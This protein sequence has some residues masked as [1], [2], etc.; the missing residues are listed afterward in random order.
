MSGASFHLF[1][2]TEGV[3]YD[4]ERESILTSTPIASGPVAKGEPTI[5]NKDGLVSIVYNDTTKSWD[6]A[7]DV[8]VHLKDDPNS[9]KKKGL[10]KFYCPF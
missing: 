4:F 8:M 9:M 2:F 1:D 5:Y 10:R 7:L 6:C 3:Q